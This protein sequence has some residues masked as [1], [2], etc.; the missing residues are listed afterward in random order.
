M[1]WDCDDDAEVATLARIV[2]D[3]GRAQSHRKKRLPSIARKH[4][5]L[6][7]RMVDANLVDDWLDRP[8]DPQELECDEWPAHA[9]E[10]S[11]K[12]QA[13]S[14]EER[15]ESPIRPVFE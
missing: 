10:I 12:P 11:A 14:E 3:L 13:L 15:P 2:A 5:D 8:P 7:K 6:W 4:P 1:T 9:T